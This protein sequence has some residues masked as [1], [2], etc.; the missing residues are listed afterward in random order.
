[1][2]RALTPAVE[3][4][5]QGDIIAAGLVEMLFDSGPVRLW[6][7]IGDLPFQG[8]TYTGAGTLGD[9]SSVQESLG[10]RANGM[11]FT[12]SGASQAMLDL[13]KSEPVQ[14]RTVNTWVALFDAGHA[15]M[16]DP[17]KVH[18]GLADTVQASDAGADSVITLSVEGQLVDLK[19]P[20]ERRYYSD[21][22]QQRGFSGDRFF[23]FAE[24]LLDKTIFWGRRRLDPPKA[25]PDAGTP[26]PPAAPVPPPPAFDAPDVGLGGEGT[27][28]SGPGSAPGTSIGEPGFPGNVA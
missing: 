3:T 15:L 23:E 11:T 16:E 13:A 26:E 4:A 18:S 7:G 10:L 6:T 5:V 20:L 9:M 24:D 27:A 2:T 12:Y 19:R 28:I 17:L 21:Q 14:G 8:N 1:M 22:D 25:A